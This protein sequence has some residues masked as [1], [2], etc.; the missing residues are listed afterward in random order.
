MNARFHVTRIMLLFVAGLA[1]NLFFVAMPTASILPDLWA[2]DEK[3]PAVKT[4]GELTPAEEEFRKQMTGSVLVGVFSIDGRTGS[5]KEE[6]YE[7]SEVR[8][9]APGKADNF[10]WLITSRIKYGDKDVKIPVPVEVRWAGDTPMIQLTNT[11]IPLM[12]T[13]TARVM[14]YKDRYAGTWQH[15]AV[16][17]HMWGKIEKAPE[18]TEP[19]K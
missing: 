17:G 7:I 13:F 12:G 5:P 14:I 18:S 2:E 11:T 15:D 8:K 1:T 19:V 16:G 4:A 9:V 10:V 6:R 3:S